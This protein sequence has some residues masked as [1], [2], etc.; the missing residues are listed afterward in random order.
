MVRNLLLSMAL[1]ASGS[2]F[3]QVSFNVVAAPPPPEYERVPVVPPGYVWAPGYWA[4]NYDSHI[5]VRGRTMVQR[6]GYRWEPDRWEQRDGN[7]SRKVGRWEPDMAMQAVPVKGMKKPKHKQGQTHNGK[8]DSKRT[9]ER[10]HGRN[11]G[12]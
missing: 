12:R 5:W 7:Y 10:N 4:W 11:T 8:P 3:A 9:D 6:A 1:A 2:A